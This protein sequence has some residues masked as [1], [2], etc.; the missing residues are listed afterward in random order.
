MRAFAIDGFTLP[1]P[2]HH[3]F[4]ASKYALLRRRVEAAGWA[5]LEVP[6]AASDTEILR[7]HSAEYLCKVVAGELT[8]TEQQAIGLP[9]SPQ[10]VER[11]RRSVG[12]TL[13]ACR[14]A[15]DD[16]VAVSLSG[17][18][19]HAFRDHGEGFCVFNDCAVAARSLQ[20]EGLLERVLI[21][22]CDVHQ[23][24]GSAA[25]LAGDD[26]VFTF[27]IH[28]A[29]NYPF[30][31]QTSDLDVA[32]PD[33]AGDAQ[34]LAALEPALAQA[35]ALAT[36]EIVVYLAGADPYAGDRLGKLS[37]SKK[38]LGRRDRLI[39]EA[40]R[41]RCVPVAVVMGGGYAEPIEDTVDIY[42]RTLKAARWLY[43][44]QRCRT[45]LAHLL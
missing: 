25:I 3:R 45:P 18:T 33:S 22:D 10:L 27:S 28:A 16:G 5:R 1:L 12:A 26:Y 13:A 7:A 14:A 35:F 30:T 40:C 21:V 11:A 4:P 24:D 36:P 31:K 41:A 37:L 38:G 29:N 9:W 32:L 8:G 19:H 15:L 42:Y 34:Y 39:F 2:V 23:G 44:S 6:A 43:S 17:G 20:A